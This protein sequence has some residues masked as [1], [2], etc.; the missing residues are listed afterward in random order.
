[1]KI[2]PLCHSLSSF[3]SH[4]HWILLFG[5]LNFSY[6]KQQHMCGWLTGRNQDT[7]KKNYCVC[8]CVWSKFILATITDI[9]ILITQTNKRQP[10]TITTTT[11]NDQ[12]EWTF[13]AFFLLLLQ[14]N[15]NNNNH[16]HAWIPKDF[17][18]NPIH[19]NLI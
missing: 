14:I 1:M 8:L 16:T 5:C 15:N 7:K 9:I 11:K 19:F 13:F 2:N 17:F 10:A 18:F 3:H 6:Q 12:Q 4:H